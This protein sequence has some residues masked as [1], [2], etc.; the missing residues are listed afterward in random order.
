VYKRFQRVSD[1]I[2]NFAPTSS[3]GETRRA[4]GARSCGS[5]ASEAI[6]FPRA[7]SMFSSLCGAIFGPFALA[8][9]ASLRRDLKD[10]SALVQR[11]ASDAPAV[12]NLHRA[13][14]LDRL[15]AAAGARA[16]A[17]P[18]TRPCP[19]GLRNK[20]RTFVSACQEIVGCSLFR[21]DRAI[22]ARVGSRADLNHVLAGEDGGRIFRTTD[23]EF[24]LSL[25]RS[26]LGVGRRRP[27]NEPHSRNAAPVRTHH[28]GSQ[29]EEAAQIEQSDVD[30]LRRRRRP[31][32]E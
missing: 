32:L 25:S 31:L 23:I 13:P 11:I 2:C 12:A 27:A 24:A 18:D 5:E 3:C 17:E 1:K 15:G 8:S 14:W 16:S 22:L 26:A 6:Q 4:R 21:P 19:S 7:E 20:D 30:G 29:A 28:A 9:N 10:K